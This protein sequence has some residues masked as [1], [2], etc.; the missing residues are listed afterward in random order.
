MRKNHRQGPGIG[1]GITSVL[2]V[3]VALC[4]TIFAAL[5]FFSAR[6][7]R[8][9]SDKA[10]ETT[11]EYYAADSKAEEAVADLAA[12]LASGTDLPEGFTAQQAAGELRYVC[13]FTI[14]DTRTLHVELAL[15]NGAL[16]RRVWQVN[17][18]AGFG[19]SSLPVL[20]G[21]VTPGASEG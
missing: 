6:A 19:E 10:A 4:V 11:T 1:L 20:Q 15:N 14:S 12:S 21:P 16:T 7:D 8:D 9:L 5:S 3:F 2:T 17:T 13:D 18:T